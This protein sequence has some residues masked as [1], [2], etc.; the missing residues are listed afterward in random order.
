[1]AKALFTPRHAHFL[2]PLRISIE[3]RKA[4][5]KEPKHLSGWPIRVERR[6]CEKKGLQDS[7]VSWQ[8]ILISRAD[9]LRAPYWL[10]QPQR[11]ANQ[12]RRLYNII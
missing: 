5:A 9:K 7:K 10:S 8:E 1:M 3:I 12:R 6:Q 11:L 4:L 2:T